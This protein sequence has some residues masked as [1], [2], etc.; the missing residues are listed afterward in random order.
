MLRVLVADADPTSRSGWVALLEAER[1]LRARPA[2][3][4]AELVERCESADVVL[5]VV[6]DRTAPRMPELLAA[7]SDRS[8]TPVV[9]LAATATDE[10]V[11]QAIE[12][13]AA[14]ALVADAAPT[15]VVAAVHAAAGGA[16]VDTHTGMVPVTGPLV[17]RVSHEA[18]PL[19]A[20]EVEILALAGEG[21]SNQ[22]IAGRLYVSVSTV[23]SHLSHAFGRLGVRHRAAAIAEA[24]RRRML[25]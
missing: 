10:L 23:K 18:S 11:P 17:Q 1:D 6:G 13:G 2:V 20:K 14:G 9:V 22:E 24:R 16:R 15:Q 4:A 8:E 3:S 12:Q 7:V 5:L 19:T 25:P 21:L